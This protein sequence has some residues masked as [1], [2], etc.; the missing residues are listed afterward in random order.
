MID[1]DQFTTRSVKHPG[2]GQGV[3]AK[4]D[5]TLPFLHPLPSSS[6]KMGAGGGGEGGTLTMGG[7][8]GRIVDRRKV[9]AGF[10]VSHF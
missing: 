10:I 9:L 6:I 4:T 7:G 8:G 2:S 3:P 1:E 5:S